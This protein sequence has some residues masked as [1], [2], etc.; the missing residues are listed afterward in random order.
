MTIT[1]T[2]PLTLPA[3]MEPDNPLWRYALA[4]WQKPELA[5]TCLDLQAQGWSVTRILCAGWLGVNGRTF[6]GIEDAKVTEWREHVTGRIRSARKSI[7][8]D[9]GP[10][11][12]LRSALAKAELQAEQ[13]ELALAWQ[14]LYERNPEVASMQNC[15]TVTVQNLLSAAPLTTRELH[16][17]TQ[18]TKLAG[19]LA[20]H[21]PR[22]TEPC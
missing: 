22:S 17:M 8:R 15:T 14:T 9:H 2:D 18:I 4:C 5:E 11:Q 16:P 21:S 19:L 6:T 1:Q 13:T 12:E 7:P 3:L 10:T 20:E